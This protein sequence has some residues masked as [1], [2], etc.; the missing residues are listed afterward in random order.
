[1]NAVRQG[2]DHAA[3]EGVLTTLAAVYAGAGYAPVTTAH[4]FEADTLI[5]LY[6]EDIRARAFLFPG[7]GGG[8]ELCL[9]PDFTVPVVRAHGAGGGGVM[10]R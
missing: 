5:D 3:L 8:N 10:P 1:V 7:S 4:L 9:R 2:Q 6:G